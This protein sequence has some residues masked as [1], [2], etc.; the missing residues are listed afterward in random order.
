MLVLPF[1]GVATCIFVQDFLAV[2]GLAIVL[3]LVAKL[4]VDTGAESTR[5]S[6]TQL[7]KIGTS[8]SS[9]KEISG[10]G[11]NLFFPTNISFASAGNLLVLENA[12]ILSRVSPSG[13]IQIIASPDLSKIGF[14]GD[15]KPAMQ[16]TFFFP[17]SLTVDA[18]WNIFIADSYNNR[19][20]AIKAPVP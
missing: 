15:N 19:I 1:L 2:R 4:M 3:L 18:L 12:T 6:A 20:R 13:Q 8:R 17:Y 14:W 5:I 10:R 11:T 9:K 7:A 16:A